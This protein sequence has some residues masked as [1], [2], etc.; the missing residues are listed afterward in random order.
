MVIVMVLQAP[1]SP[2]FL[3]GE[4]VFLMLSAIGVFVGWIIERGRPAAD[5][6]FCTADEFVN[7][8]TRSGGWVPDADFSDAEMRAAQS[9][10][11]NRSVKIQ[12]GGWADDSWYYL[13]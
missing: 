13:P 5:D 12:E 10:L 8:I 2:C 1:C 4:R 11:R 6:R 7:F 3:A 9:A